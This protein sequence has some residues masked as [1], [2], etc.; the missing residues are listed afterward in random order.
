MMM[1]RFRFQ[2]DNQQYKWMKGYITFEGQ[3]TEHMIRILVPKKENISDEQTKAAVVLANLKKV[4]LV[5]TLTCFLYGSIILF[6]SFRG[7]RTKRTKT[8]LYR[9][10]RLHLIISQ[11]PFNYI[12]VINLRDKLNKRK[13]PSNNSEKKRPRL[14]PENVLDVQETEKK[15]VSFNFNLVERKKNILQANLFKEIRRQEE[16]A[17]RATLAVNLGVKLGKSLRYEY[18]NYFDKALKYDHCA[19]REKK[20]EILLELK[21]RKSDLELLTEEQTKTASDRENFQ[22]LLQ[23]VSP[24]NDADIKQFILSH[25]N[26]ADE[27]MKDIE[28][29]IKSKKLAFDQ[30]LKGFYQDKINLEFRTAKDNFLK[31]HQR[32]HDYIKNESK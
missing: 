3:I 19:A 2:S 16:V 25:I 32:I 10:F 12:D 30:K 14:E 6:I 1:N 24:S 22:S 31:I 23:L 29:K 13:I 20:I 18:K 27:K 5:R 8:F 9:K 28:N 26:D 11:R 17:K 15:S 4:S 21:K 7:R